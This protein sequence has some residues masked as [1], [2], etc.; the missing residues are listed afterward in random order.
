MELQFFM[1]IAVVG[2]DFGHKK[3]YVFKLISLAFNNKSHMLWK[4]NYGGFDKH[5]LFQNA[6]AT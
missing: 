4:T 6:S 2:W 5:V 3:V 1:F